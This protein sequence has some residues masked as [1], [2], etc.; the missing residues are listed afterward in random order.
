MPTNPLKKSIA[1]SPSSKASL[2]ALACIF[3]S[4][5]FFRLA[6]AEGEAPFRGSET[7][8]TGH[9]CFL[10]KNY[11]VLVTPHQGG[12][13]EDIQAWPR[14]K[15]EIASCDAKKMPFLNQRG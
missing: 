10:Y 6:S 3:S 4:I 7:A 9:G 12:V 5:L 15:D 14:K 8:E 2:I 13:G 1:L 11:A